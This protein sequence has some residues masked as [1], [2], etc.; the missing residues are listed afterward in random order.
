MGSEAG[1][2]FA[3]PPFLHSFSS[4]AFAYDDQDALD[5][6]SFFSR[7][8]SLRGRSRPESLPGNGGAVAGAVALRTPSSR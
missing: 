4:I 7:N 2:P 3:G 8:A 1:Q 6:Q 5:C